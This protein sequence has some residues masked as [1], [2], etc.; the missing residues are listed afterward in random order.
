MMNGS[1]FNAYVVH[2][3]NSNLMSR[4]MIVISNY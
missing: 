4:L 2:G 3:S 1:M